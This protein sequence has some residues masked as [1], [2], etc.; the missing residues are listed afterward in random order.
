MTW[1]S[2]DEVSVRIGDALVESKE[3]E[4]DVY[5]EVGDLLKVACLAVPVSFVDRAN[6]T[7]PEYKSYKNRK[8]CSIPFIS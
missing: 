2:V 4:E 3:T 7:E 5:K 1:N 8:C 6:C